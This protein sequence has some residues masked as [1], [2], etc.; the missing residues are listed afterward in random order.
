MPFLNYFVSFVFGA[1]FVFLLVRSGPTLHQKKVVSQLK[2]DKQILE[3][4]KI[5]LEN[6]N[7]DLAKII[8]QLQQEY[9]ALKE[10]DEVLSGQV[11]LCLELLGGI[12]SIRE[13]TNIK[14]QIF[15]TKQFLK[16]HEQ[17]LPA[18]DQD[19]SLQKRSN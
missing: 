1:G 9:K 2:S 12:T 16:K 5:N 4:D 17:F 18:S 11:I 3:E 15:V 13:N 10:S 6:R 7:S 14:A 19:S 8:N